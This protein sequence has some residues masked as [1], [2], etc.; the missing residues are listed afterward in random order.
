MSNEIGPE[1]ARID[2]HFAA[3]RDDLDSLERGKRCEHCGVRVLTINSLCDDCLAI[4]HRVG[5]GN[6]G[7]GH[8][9]HCP[10]NYLT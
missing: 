5:C 6:T 2:A 10:C 8:A 3:V 4:N 1:Q 7:W 9:A